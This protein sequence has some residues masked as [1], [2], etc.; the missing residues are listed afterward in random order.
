M[1]L[2][3]LPDPWDDEAAAVARHLTALQASGLSWPAVADT[4]RPWLQTLR[5]HPAP[6]WAMEGLLQAY[7][8]SSAQGLALMRLA[9]A[10]LRIPDPQTAQ[11]LLDDQLTRGGF[12][13]TALPPDSPHPWWESLSR[14]VLSVVA[15]MAHAGSAGHD[16][17]ST[18][19]ALLRDLGQ[20]VTVRAT[21]HAVQLLGEQ[22]V[23]APQIED[24][25]RRARLDSE[26]ARQ[27]GWQTCWS[28]DMLGEGART[29]ADAD[30]HFASYEHALNHLID[31]PAVDG[32]GARAASGLSIKLSALHPRF[33]AVRAEEVV[34]QLTPRLRSLAVLA[35]HHRLLLTIDAEES[36]RLE[37]QLA[38]LQSLLAGL[39]QDTHEAVRSWAGLG[40]AVQAYQLRAP[41][42]IARLAELARTHDRLLTV[43]LV[44]GAYWDGEIKRAQEL[45]LPGY[46]VYTSKAHTDLS[47]LA[48]AQQ[49]LSEVE[50]LRPQFATHNAVTIAAV[51]HLATAAGVG[52][53]QYEW[54]RL[55]GMGDATYAA[56]RAAL[57]HEAM[58]PVRVYAPVGPHRDLLAYLVRRLLENGANSSFVHQMADAH[59]DVDAMLAPPWRDVPL[60][61][62]PSPCDAWGDDHMVAPG[63]DL[64]HG[65]HRTAL[66]DAVAARVARSGPA[67]PLARLAL[68]ADQIPAIMISLQAA[69][70]DWESRGWAARADVLIQAANRMTAELDSWAAELVAEAH[71]TLPDAVAEV[72][73]T[74]D[75]A[76]YYARMAQAY[77]VPRGLP[78][79]E[80]EHNSWQLRGRGVFVCIA[81]WNFPLAIFGGQVMAALL[82]GNAV[83]AKSAPQT[84][85][86]AERFVRLLHA[87]G[88]PTGAL[89]HAPGDASVGAALVAH[90]TCAGVAFTGSTTAA[91]RIQLALAAPDRPIVPLIA[92]TGGL[93]AMIVDSSAL[94]EQVVDAVMHSAF[95]SA[96][97]RCSALRLLC[98]HEAVATPLEA[99]LAGALQCL[100]V[101]APEHPATDVGP[102]IDE[103]AAGRLRA[104]EHTL[105]TWAR[106]RRREVICLARATLHPGCH[107][108]LLPDGPPRQWIVPSIWRLPTVA[109]LDAEHFGPILHVVHWG[110]GTSAP[111]LSALIDQINARGF[112]LTM[113][114]HTRVDG[115]IDAVARAARV[116]N[117]Y[118]NRGM[119]GAVVGAQPFGGQG[120][121]GTG[122]KAGGPLYLSRFAT[123]QV[124]SHNTAA[125]GGNAALL[126]QLTR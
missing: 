126:A 36:D 22:F 113:G 19:T 30:R 90:P 17:G 105:D 16:T 53:T 70:P 115:R 14:R 92:E 58:A 31:A 6:F 112:G 29:W 51:M 35:A 1:A 49:L 78:G 100:R 63:R 106:E 18:L 77:A 56:I 109:D 55:H 91:K 111:T 84:P 110:P 123:E 124:I 72:R 11:C 68:T 33:E 67:N 103:V 80:G 37:L 121:S 34:S 98:L 13:H 27:H 97:Q 41:A 44:K 5:D 12:A 71:K 122:P 93:N 73:E 26:A 83:A 8:L 75:F 65:P 48:C 47:Y 96:G 79:P 95:G 107:V 104:W 69:W 7:P 24:A 116:G 60:P 43:R 74:I 88:V 38:V 118:V 46:P 32:D 85:G 28:F 50:V 99:M 120:W 94:P 66:R 39:A 119:T 86:V 125:A 82:A 76:H 89:V 61:S 21:A 15:Q 57:P 20:S 81:P 23:L 42:V 25:W 108:R 9:E 54:Q 114:L 4:A 117:L 3:P 62:M 45:G 59:T 87:C 102:V 64:A 2:P 40:V 10:L 52:P 101:G